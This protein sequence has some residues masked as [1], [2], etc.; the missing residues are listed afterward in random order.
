MFNVFSWWFVRGGPYRLWFVVCGLWF[1]PDGYVRV[2]K[3]TNHE[4]RT[5]LFESSQHLL[6]HFFRRKRRD[7]F[8][9]GAAHVGAVGIGHGYDSG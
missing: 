1:L 6:C 3:T 9:P 7:D 8:L 2:S 5:Q 4:L